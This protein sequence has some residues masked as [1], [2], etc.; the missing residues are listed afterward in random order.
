MPQYP[1][2]TITTVAG[3][4]KPGYSGDGG[5]A[6]EAR[7]NWPRD[8]SPAPDGDLYIADT[9][10]HC[11]RR[12]SRD[13]TIT[14]V[15]GTGTE[16]YSGDGGQAVHAE[17]NAP[18][19]VEV[20][21]DGCL[22]VADTSNHCIRKVGVD[23]IIS[24]VAGTGI[25]GYS[26]DG[27]RATDARLAWPQD[28]AVGAD[29]TLY[30]T[31]TGNHRVRTVSPEGS[32]ETVAGT[33]ACGDGGDGGPAVRARLARPRGVFVEAAG[34]LYIGDTENHRVRRVTPDAIISTVAGNGVEGYGGDG[35]EAS[36]AQLAWPRGVVTTGDGC[37]YIADCG[38]SVVR[39]VHPDGTIST[40]AGT[41][42]EGYSGDGG[43]ATSAQLA[44]PHGLAL[45][46]RG[47][48]YIAEPRNHRVRKVHNARRG[49][50][51]TDV[52]TAGGR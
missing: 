39:A 14:T 44:D 31:D 21:A 20:G 23:G 7:L 12:V 30:F 36:A 29:G 41:G 1:I 27:G 35:G 3:N 37:L 10:N 11:I 13:G 43:P 38:N 51:I 34:C 42:T 22:Y 16:G 49:L 26:G 8:M 52:S 46:A 28:V 40:V 50:P 25:E 15:A 45:D 19:D 24:T 6:V 9:M 4:G 48:L 17:L 18:R 5:P 2:G 33:G 47:D 32:I